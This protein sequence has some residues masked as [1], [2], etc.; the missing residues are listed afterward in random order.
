M[1]LANRITVARGALAIALWGVLHAIDVG[2]VERGGLWWVAFAAFVVTAATDSLDGWVARRRGEVSVFGRIAD[3]FVDKIMILG[4]LT[5]LMPLTVWM[6]GWIV[7]LILA[8]E[9][10]VSGIRD[11]AE[12]RGI[13]FPASFWGKT[14]MVS[15]SAAVAAACLYVGHPDSDLWK[16]TFLALLWWTIAAT[17]ISGAIYLFHARRLLFSAAPEDAAPQGPA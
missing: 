7:V 12:G 6:R 3:P 13:P 5:L 17:L 8:R 1:G 11:F 16:Y 2:G 10:L 4:A 15:Q 9:L 14:K